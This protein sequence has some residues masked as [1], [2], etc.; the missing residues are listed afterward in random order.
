MIAP[1]SANTINK[2]AH[3]IADNLL[4]Q[5]VLACRTPLLLAPSANTAM[6]E[7]TA[8][9]SSLLTLQN[10]GA[11]L[12]SS[13]VGELACKDIG[14]G[15]MAEP[16][17]IFYAT[18]REL[19]KE[20]FW[21]EKK[22]LIT[23]GGTIERIDDVRFISNFSSGK[24]ASELSKALYFL[25][26]NVTLLTSKE[27]HIPKEIRVVKYE[28]TKELMGLIEK[29]PFEYLFMASAVSDF[30]LKQPT[31]GK[32]KKDGL[33]SM[34][35]ELDKNIDILSSLAK[36]GKIIGFK[37]ELDKKSA[38]DNAKKMLKNKN[39]HAV[40]L[41]VIDERNP[42]GGDTNEMTIFLTD[43]EHEIKRARKLDVAFEIA[44]IVGTHGQ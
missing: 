10:R 19:L 1:A 4:T 14:N 20:S 8:T 41:N 27:H 25:G 37:A 44:K 34:T 21:S 35:L 5:A 40:C 18:I 17:E 15:A 9:Q 11:K 13:V 30:V 6:I 3:G 12:I 7:H 32:I 39:L 29:N 33:D 31:K 43:K 2:L 28:S 24:M 16:K 23:G 42:F 22:V 26:A 38:K 36:G